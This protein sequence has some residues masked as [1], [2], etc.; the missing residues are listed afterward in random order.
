VYFGELIRGGGMVSK[1]IRS[2]EEFGRELAALKERLD[3]SASPFL[4]RGHGD[5]KYSLTTTLERTGCGDMSFADYFRLVANQVKPALETF[6]GRVWDVPDYGPE[7][8]ALF[9]DAERVLRLWPFGTSETHIRSLPRPAAAPLVLLA[10][11][12][13]AGIVSTTLGVL[14]RQVMSELQSAVRSLAIRASS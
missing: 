9:A 4:F 5:S 6:T 10:G 2:W 3:I 7:I 8:E 11:A 1:E 14:R 13:R 12:A